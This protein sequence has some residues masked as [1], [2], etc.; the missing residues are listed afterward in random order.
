MAKKTS[1]RIIKKSLSSK[2]LSTKKS[3]INK[4][5]LEM[6][7]KI[8][9]V[10]K[11]NEEREKNK[12][13]Q[14][15]I[16]KAMK[17]IKEKKKKSVLKKQKPYDNKM[18]S[19]L[20]DLSYE[21]NDTKC[22][23]M[24]NLAEYFCY[25]GVSNQNVSKTLEIIAYKCGFDKRDIKGKNKDD[26]CNMIIHSYQSPNILSH[27]YYN[28]GFILGSI[29]N[30]S[31]SSVVRRLRF[32]IIKHILEG[33]PFIY[34]S[35][36]RETDMSSIRTKAYWVMNSFQDLYI[37]NYYIDIVKTWAD[38]GRPSFFEKLIQLKKPRTGLSFGRL[39]H[40]EREVMRKMYEILLYIKQKVLEYKSHLE[41]DS[42]ILKEIESIREEIRRRN[43]EI[44]RMKRERRK[45]EMKE[46]RHQE[47]M[48]TLR[49]RNNLNNENN[50]N[51]VNNIF[52][53]NDD[54]FES[55]FNLSL[56]LF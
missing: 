51:N 16:D 33:C 23:N 48:D 39:T 1:L 4:K 19:E 29:F 9:Q 35:I 42:K 21:G 56:R 7:V 3:N 43:E 46:R 13:Y 36:F 44:E 41:S 52:V 8:Q 25:N 6:A 34:N 55:G 30:W 17:E 49:D 26:L 15:E 47:H 31:S 2:K 27:L 5:D 54:P 38:L 40:Q 20:I 50:T 22:Y 10:I 24:F 12:V 28:L 53:N 18:I 14:Q 11:D 32:I 45:E 37:L